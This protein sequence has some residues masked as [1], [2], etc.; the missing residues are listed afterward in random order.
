MI[1]NYLIIA[2]RNLYLAKTQTLIKI[3]GLALALSISIVIFSWIQ[4]EL[5]YDKFHK[6]YER[7]YRVEYNNPLFTDATHVGLVCPAILAPTL[8]KNYPEVETVT[9]I[10]DP[11]WSQPKVLMQYK[12]K[13][14]YEEKYLSI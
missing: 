9:R 3:V 2:L 4:N 14:F 7:I 10:L 12:D 1:K 11:S 13:Q 6:N 5:S 8:K